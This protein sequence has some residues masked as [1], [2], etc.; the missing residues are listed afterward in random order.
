MDTYKG[1]TL[2][3]RKKGKTLYVSYKH[4]LLCNQIKHG[5]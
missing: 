4:L 5:V 2:Q 1:K 3:F